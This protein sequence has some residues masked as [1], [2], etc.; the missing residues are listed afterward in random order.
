MGNNIDAEK[1]PLI[2]ERTP[3]PW[4]GVR[5]VTHGVKGVSRGVK[6]E[7]RKLPHGVNGVKITGWGKTPYKSYPTLLVSI[8][9]I[10]VRT[11]R[12]SPSPADTDTESLQSP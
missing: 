8:V 12:V 9:R 10:E 11:R 1:Y 4:G 3:F 2:I 5:G 6:G 7:G